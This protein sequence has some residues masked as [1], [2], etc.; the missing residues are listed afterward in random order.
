MDGNA[1]LTALVGFKVEIR[2]KTFLCGKYS[3]SGPSNS[4][5]LE[6]LKYIIHC[7][8]KSR[9]KQNSV[10]LLRFR[11]K[12]NSMIQGSSTKKNPLR[13]PFHSSSV[14]TP[15]VSALMTKIRN[16][17]HNKRKQVLSAAKTQLIAYTYTQS[18]K[19]CGV[20][21]ETGTFCALYIGMISRF[22]PHS[23]RP[24]AHWRTQCECEK[25]GSVSRPVSRRS[26]SPAC[27]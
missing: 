5:R 9:S 6:D 25:E 15:F 24:P 8:S 27:D 7:S 26:E 1:T 18:G 19:L 13:S 17:N 16:R 23:P 21:G 11:P 4:T 20:G 10:D 2:N 3:V 12:R 14:Q 22:V